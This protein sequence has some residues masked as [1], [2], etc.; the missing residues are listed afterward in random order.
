LK[1]R[2]PG[3]PEKLLSKHKFSESRGSFTAGSPKINFRQD[4]IFIFISIYGIYMINEKNVD[5]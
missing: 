3:P 2:P 1:N 4:Y 5:Y